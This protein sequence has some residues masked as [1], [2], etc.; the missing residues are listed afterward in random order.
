MVKTLGIGVSDYLID[1]I[2]RV[3]SPKNLNL[4]PDDII[5]TS[6][7]INKLK[8]FHL[9]AF[10][11]SGG[12]G[13]Q[14][15]TNVNR[16][17]GINSNA[18]PNPFQNRRSLGGAPPAG[19]FIKLTMPR[20]RQYENNLSYSSFIMFRIKSHST[21]VRVKPGGARVLAI[22]WN[23]GPYFFGSPSPYPLF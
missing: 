6:V 21:A 7:S 3:L 10:G 22:V 11:N 20:Q 14:P 19:T 8:Y 13:G 4:P 23:S 16:F 9:A 15:K 18:N 2:A 5:I 17:S 1:N 12:G